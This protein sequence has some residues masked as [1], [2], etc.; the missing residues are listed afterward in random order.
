MNIHTA[1]LWRELSANQG[2]AVAPPVPAHAHWQGIPP[3][4]P[5]VKNSS[6]QDQ[7]LA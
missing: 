1:R 4:R 3:L 7:P 2:E 5:A 6:V